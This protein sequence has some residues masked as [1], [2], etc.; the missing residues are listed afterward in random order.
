MKKKG[1]LY[2]GG[3]KYGSYKIPFSHELIDEDGNLL[4]SCLVNVM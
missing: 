4:E 3:E 1:E 2:E